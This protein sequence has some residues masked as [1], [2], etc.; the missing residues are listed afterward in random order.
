MGR[1]DQG[2]QPGR[3]MAGEGGGDVGGGDPEAD[4]ELG[5]DPG[6]TYTGLAPVRIS[7]TSSDLCRSRPTITSSPGPTAASR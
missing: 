7:P 3:G 1:A 2:D 6:A 4:A 5:V